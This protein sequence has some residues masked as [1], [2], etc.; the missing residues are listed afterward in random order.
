MER[1]NGKKE[2]NYLCTGDLGFIYNNELYITGREKDLIIV[3]GR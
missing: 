3:R 2:E 1:K